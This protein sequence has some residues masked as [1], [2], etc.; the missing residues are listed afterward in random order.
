VARQELID[1]RDTLAARRALF[2]AIKSG[3]GRPEAHAV[4]GELLL[5]SR[6]KYG[7]LELEVAAYLKPDDWVTDRNLVLGLTAEQLDEPA[8]DALRR[9]ARLKPDWRSDTLLTRAVE[10]LN[11]RSAP[12]GGVVRF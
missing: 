2:S 4:L 5:E 11:R 1:R 7:L 9:L 12:S 6:P 10:A 3:I 8:S